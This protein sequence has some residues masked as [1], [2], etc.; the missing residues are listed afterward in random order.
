MKL[1]NL[2][3]VQARS[4]VALLALAPLLV[5]C[6]IQPPEDRDTGYDRFREGRAQDPIGVQTGRLV[7][8]ALDM[9][10]GGPLNGAT[11]DIVSAPSTSQQPIH[12]RRVGVSDRRGMVTFNDVPQ[13]V[14]LVVTH[15][16]GVYAV[17]NYVVP[18]S[19]WSEFH[20]YV[21][22]T[23]PRSKSECLG[24]LLCGL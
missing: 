18:Q 14:N 23:G 2:A 13:M 4:V 15:A 7:V 6:V 20:V 11:V 16:R 10:D 3:H 12:Y 24:Q 22:T 1:M 8:V 5:A 9:A 17:D 21:D 19:G